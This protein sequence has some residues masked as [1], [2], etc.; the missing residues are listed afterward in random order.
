MLFKPG[1]LVR[2]IFGFINVIKFSKKYGWSQDS[3]AIEKSELF[4]VI[5]VVTQLELV[6]LSKNGLLVS[7]AS[8]FTTNL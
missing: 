3:I 7:Y 4:L 8:Q 2:P 5:Q 1:D 6:L